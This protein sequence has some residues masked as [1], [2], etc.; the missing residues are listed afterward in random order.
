VHGPA[1][2]SYVTV[3]SGSLGTAFTSVLV[4]V[5]GTVAEYPFVVEMNDGVP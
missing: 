5:A 4:V 1:D 2:D 3:A